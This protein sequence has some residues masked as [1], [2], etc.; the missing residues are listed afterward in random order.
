MTK[1]SPIQD[2][3]RR[4]QLARNPPTNTSATLPID[5]LEHGLR[6]RQ[7]ELEVKIEELRLTLVDVVASRDRYVDLY[8]FAPVGYLTLTFGGM[9][10]EVNFTGATLLGMELNKL[11]RCQFAR[12]ITAEEIAIWHRFLSAVQGG[13]RHSCELL[14]RRS[15]DFTFHAHLDGMYSEARDNFPSMVRITLADISERKQAEEVL[16]LS[17]SCFRG[18][19]ET[20]AHGMALVSTQGRLLKVNQTLCAIFGYGEEELLATDLQTITHPDDREIDAAYMRQLLA[21]T[22]SV[23]QR[24]KRYFHRDGHVI[25]VLLRVA[26]VWDAN[27]QPLHCV[28][29]IQDITTQRVSEA[30]LLAAKNQLEL[31]VGCVNR[32]QSLFIK[33]SHSD[34]VFNTLLMEVMRLTT[35][36]YGFI[37]EV[38]Q[39]LQGGCG[40]QTL[41]IFSIVQDEKTSIHSENG[42]SGFQFTKTSGQC[43]ETILS[44][45]PV[46]ANDLSAKPKHYALPLSHPPLHA[47]LEVP[48][49]RGENI[50]AVLGLANRPHGYDMAL[51]EYLGPVISACAQIVE[52]Y[53]NR[54]KRLEIEENLFN[55]EELLRATFESTRDGILVMSKDGGVLQANARFREIWQISKSISLEKEGGKLLKSAVRQVEEP[56]RF[57]KLL[58]KLS[59]SDITDTDVVRCKDGRILDRFSAPLFGKEG[60]SGRVWIFTD[61]TEQKRHEDTLRESEHRMHEISATL[62]EGLCVINQK[63]QITLINPTA[64]TMLGWQIDE[65]LGHSFHDLFHHSHMDGSPYPFV[66]C[67][68]WSVLS[69]GDVVTMEE[70]W[71]WHR[72]GV[73]I[74]MALIASPILRSGDVRGAVLAFRDITERKQLEASLVRSKEAVE[75]AMQELKKSNDLLE[76]LFN[77]TYL[78]VVF[79]DRDFDFIRV[80]RSYALACAL[81]EAFFQGKN[82]FA[83]YPHE[84]TEAIFRQVIE[85]G[86]PF[87][88]TAKPFGFPDH[89]EWGVTYW[90]WTLYP[91]KNDQGMVEWLIFALLDVTEN[92]RGEMALL[93]AKEQAEAA[94]RAKGEF[95]ASMSHEIRTPMNV[96]LGMSELLLETDLNPTQRNFAQTMHSSGSA[97]LVII[98]DVLDFSRV[99]AGCISLNE[100]P[101]FPRRVLEIT[102]R[103]LQMTSEI[104]GLTLESE[105]AADVPDVVLGDEGRIRQ[106][107]INLL[108]NAIKFTH[109]GRV[110]VSL[111]INPQDS[112]T[113]LFKVVDTGI[114][115]AQEQ[116][117]HVF[118]RFTQA[119]MGITRNYGGTGLG[120][121]ISQRLV[122]LM[123]GRIW[124]ESCLGKGS[125]FFFTLP[126]LIAETTN[127]LDTDE[128]QHAVVNTRSLRILLAED[129]E[130]N[131]VLFE[132]Y[133]LQT[134][135]QL[136]M[137]DDGVEAVARVQKEM[138]DVVVMDIQMPNMDGYTATCQI[139]QWER[140]MNR[141]PVPIIALS[142][143]AMEGEIKRSQEAGCD[144]YLT[145]P[146]KKK[147]LLDVL[148]QIAS[149]S[150]GQPNARREDSWHHT[151]EQ[152]EGEL[153]QDG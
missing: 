86:E 65:V 139:R 151:C 93:Q 8:D 103:V 46:I 90:D 32:I 111:T 112:G 134:P 34:E 49:K 44:G 119:D 98:N 12:F 2:S 138:F 40:F 120:L 59:Q 29:H 39:E 113:L 35:S 107:L 100:L 123:G 78:S 33:K 18:A 96:V 13:G 106:V 80:N 133:L 108:G 122:E 148:Q 52:G 14:L 142:A 70:E 54:R 147:K 118:G 15:D 136:V 130:E 21:G 53:Q 64:L 97:L 117:A 81:D 94:S 88:V 71:L 150:N 62:A 102:T 116:I 144:L 5:E 109:Q 104:K 85:T 74:P 152:I 77:T 61:V 67:P 66:E 38:R 87:S 25:W 6:V 41:A 26:L 20:A 126:L 63:G 95:L 22:I 50:V 58:R 137:V 84:K 135:H 153:L 68:I 43:V 48:I 11:R 125:T 60:V 149:Q 42:F 55:S 82:Y 73:C 110:D 145:K 69:N 141:S 83:L 23:C 129:V 4:A 9:I 57:I 37:A 121:A 51:V 56:R 7:I 28:V 10:E 115:I 75:L 146:I 19:F 72:D 105:V 128:E 140:E 76:K 131:Q 27:G 1:K 124:V 132:A 24:E 30:E 45:H 16:R 92:K 36:T 143:H 99:E 89:P 17:E 47:L 31:Q 114:G 127:S 101:V 91:V 79:L 3:M